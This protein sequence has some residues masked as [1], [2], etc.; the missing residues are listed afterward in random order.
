MLFTTNTENTANINKTSK[1]DLLSKNG[2]SKSNKK[3]GKEIVTSEENGNPPELALK[4][5][6]P[7]IAE[8]SFKSKKIKDKDEKNTVGSR[9]KSKRKDYEGKQNDE[10]ED[11]T[12][13]VKS[14][15]TKKQKVE[16]DALKPGIDNNII[17]NDTATTS[18]FIEIETEEIPDNLKLS[19]YRITQTTADSLKKR[20][21]E[22]LFPIQAATFDIIYDGKD[23]LAR[24]KT[25][26]GKTL[27][28]ALPITEVLLKSYENG[29]LKNGQRGRAPKV[30]IMTPTRDLAKQISSEFESIAPNLKILCIYGG[31]AYD[32]QTQG[33]RSGID[34]LIGTPGRILDHI[35]R[36][37]LKLGDLKF[38]CLDEADQM[39]DIG[40]AEAMETV[41]QHVKHHKENQNKGIDYQTLLFSATVPDW[42]K[43]T[44]KKYLRTDYVNVD[45][46]K[47]TNTK[48]NENIRHIAIRSAW[49]SRKDIIGDVVTCYAGSG[50]CVI[51]CNTKNDANEL[52]LNDK[53]KQDARVLHGDIVQT[54]REITMRDFRDGKFKCIICTDV[55]ARGIDIPQ[56]DL[57]INCEPPKDID[58]YVHRAGRTARAGR[59]GIALT[60][61]KAQEENRIWNIQRCIGVSFQIVGP[62]QPQEIIAAT[63]NDAVK[64]LES[65]ESNVLPY[66]HSTAKE[67]IESQGAIGALSAALAYI[68]GY[69]GGI[70][71]R[72]LMSADEGYTT[73]L[74]RFTYPIRHTSY[75][76]SIFKK[77]FPDLPEDAVKRFS[78]TKD[79]QGVVCDISTQYLETGEDE[80]LVLA[81]R[82]WYDT[83]TTTLEVAKELPELLQIN[84]VF[85]RNDGEYGNG[86]GN[87]Y[88]NNGYRN[89]YGNKN[90]SNKWKSFNRNGNGKSNG[91]N[92]FRGNGGM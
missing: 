63:A 32:F 57:V 45:L 74:F 76:R 56:V 34:V 36:G 26:T 31:V 47:D 25:G 11:N 48:T 49:S 51:F 89:G 13:I 7:E 17:T 75:A 43:N 83:A 21:I 90:N 66:F 55:L 37:N 64:I 42:V 29:G 68:S 65:V 44:V 10:N 84:K 14:P 40:F 80:C 62:P 12:L 92:R 70:K 53:L 54:Q 8:K 18:Q 60:F 5:S 91:Y 52:V 72:S 9:P 30:I 35:D 77:H 20:G 28:F 27:A 15:K 33:L 38:I 69:S 24:A 3:K 2:K 78:M 86:Y 1:K 4:N 23:I 67:L 16:N 79:M 82:Q 50:S 41:L 6:K 71:K 19:S 73:L 85:D 81:G 22:S 61:F 59:Q 88:G 58:S 39:L 46:T 87:G